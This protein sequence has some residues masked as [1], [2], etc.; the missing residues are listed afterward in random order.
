MPSVQDPLRDGWAWA[1]AGEAV[2]VATVLRTWGS[3]PSAAGSHMV[4]SGSGRISG[5]VSGG[6]VEGAVIQAAQRLLTEGGTERLSFGVADEVAWSVG[7][8][9]GG[10][11]DIYVAPLWT[12]T[13][14][15]LFAAQDRRDILAVAHRLDGGGN[16]AV[17]LPGDAL[18]SA[19]AEALSRDA[20]VLLPGD[21]GEIFV[22]VFNPAPRLVIIGAVRIAQSLVPMA[23]L[24]GFEVI[25]IDPRESFCTAERF[26]EARLMLDW[27]D[28]ALATLGLDAATA[29]VTLTHDPKF[30]EPA[31]AEA[32]ASPAFYVGALGSRRTHAGRLLRLAESGVAQAA[33]ARIDAPIGLDIGAIGPN[34]IAVSILAGLIAARR[35]PISCVS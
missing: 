19:A 35:R 25:V 7:L 16:A 3:A 9:C 33:L 4:V 17:I 23:R 5:A 10:Q 26:P 24:A 6:C 12:E 22:E 14:P 30:D 20:P 29:V 8:A 28:S 11:I 1:E 27:P 13:L 2:A 32:L 34:E 21:E 15:A 18:A 31:L